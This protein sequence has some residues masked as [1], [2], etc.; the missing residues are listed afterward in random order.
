VV[1]EIDLI[2]STRD[3][4][5]SNVLSLGG[6]FLTDEEAKAAVQTWLETKFSGAE[7]HAR[8]IRMIDPA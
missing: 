6:R 7:R 1:K 2:A 3:H 4:N 5:D 8:R